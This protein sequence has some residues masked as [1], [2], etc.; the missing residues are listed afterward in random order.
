MPNSDAATRQKLL[1]HQFLVGFPAEI[2]KQL[3]ATGEIED[4]D[5]LI[6]RTKL[7]MTLTENENQLLLDNRDQTET[8]L[9]QVTTLTEKVAALIMANQ[10]TARQANRLLCF[11]CNR[12]GHV[13]R[14]CPSM[15]SK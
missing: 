13:Q 4:V 3:R 9:K 5:K 2:S 8:S 6:Q 12:P 10:W 14:N 15:R 7:L 11:R 1:I